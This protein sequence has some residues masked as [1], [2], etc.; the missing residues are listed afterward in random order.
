MSTQK[1]KQLT[2]FICQQNLVDENQINSWV[3]N[4]KMIPASKKLGEGYLVCRFEYDAIFSIENFVGNP[5]LLMALVSIWLTEND[6]KRH[7]DNLPAP[8][9]DVDIIDRDAADVEIGIQFREDI[10]IIPNDNGPIEF[11]GQRW[12]LGVVPSYVAN[13]AGVGDNPNNDTDKPYRY[14]DAS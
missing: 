9:M 1:L 8:D 6:S 12:E 5:T 14:G 11:N 13:V 7:D 2:D 4:G 10:E 3:E